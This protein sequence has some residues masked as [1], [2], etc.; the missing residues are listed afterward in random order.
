MSDLGY[1]VWG[2]VA[3]VI[4]TLS[5]IPIFLTWLH[6][7]LPSTIIPYLLAEHKATKAL[8]TEAIRDGLIT[9]EEEIFQF[10]L[11]IWVSTM[12]VD[13]MSAKVCAAKT[14]WQNVKNWW[15][16]LSGRVTAIRD[17]LNLIRVKLA[18]RNTEERKRLAATGIPTQLPLMTDDKDLRSILSSKTPASARAR[19]VCSTCAVATNDSR[20]TLVPDTDT[21]ATQRPLRSSEHG[22]SSSTTD[23]SDHFISD[24]D[25]HDLLAFALSHPVVKGA[26][27][28]C[29]TR[30]G[31][32]PDGNEKLHD[33]A[34]YTDG[35]AI[36]AGAKAFL[37]LL[38]RVYAM[39]ARNLGT[40]VDPEALW[41]LA[42][43]LSARD[44]DGWQ[45]A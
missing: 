33:V 31:D 12:R 4:G 28:S 24:T 29:S 5:L 3:G 17:E 13:E 43:E 21:D 11:N 34:S 39:R 44:D 2:T 26:P 37:R 42:D 27:G 32:A 8:F 40:A 6:T 15:H 18:E 16:G 36:H 1:N 23:P 9:D 14:W 30:S 38:K 25:L 22:Y 35:H 7:R 10:N 41:H 19:G 45:G 20:A